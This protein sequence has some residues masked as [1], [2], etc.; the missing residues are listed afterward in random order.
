[1]GLRLQTVASPEY[2]LKIHLE[3]QSPVFWAICLLF[4][5]VKG[6]EQSGEELE[7]RKMWQR[8]RCLK[9]TTP[10]YYHIV[11]WYGPNKY[12]K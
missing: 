1:M 6:T 12:S 10:I 3:I 7:V 4:K 11:V 2:F 9:T 8:K 5:A